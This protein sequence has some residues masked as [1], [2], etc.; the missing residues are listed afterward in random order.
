MQSN[1][2][3]LHNNEK[4]KECNLWRNFDDFS[5]MAWACVCMTLYTW[6]EA[7]VFRKYFEL[8]RSFNFTSFHRTAAMIDL[9]HDPTETLAISSNRTLSYLETPN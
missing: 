8:L 3:F 1:V 6:V 4:K 2:R 9:N 7:L 5:C